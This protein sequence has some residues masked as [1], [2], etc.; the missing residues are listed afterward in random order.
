M[1]KPSERCKMVIRQWEILKHLEERP[2]TL[3]ELAEASDPR[4]CERVI[5]RD[6]EALQAA[7][8]P[9]YSERTDVD[10]RV[11]WHLMTKGVTPARRAA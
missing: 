8:F 2:A 1:A 4:V 5:R 6:I 10:R 9:L 7:R 3:G 11:R